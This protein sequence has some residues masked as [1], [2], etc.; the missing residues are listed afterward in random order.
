[1]K[2]TNEHKD[3][4]GLEPSLE[5]EAK[6]ASGDV[7]NEIDKYSKLTHAAFYSGGNIEEKITISSPK[8]QKKLLHRPEEEVVHCLLKVYNYTH[9]SNYEIINDGQPPQHDST[10]VKIID[11]TTGRSEEIQVTVSDSGAMQG[12]GRNKGRLERKGESNELVRAALDKAING[13][14]FYAIDVRQNLILALDGWRTV[15]PNNLDYYREKQQ[16]FMADSG[17]KEI[18]FVGYTDKTI[19][20]LSP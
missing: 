4:I 15:K 3:K 1:M 8:E 18:W 20:R 14:L 16:Q 13:K 6:K 7:Y 19:L 9:N 5:I 17:F 12:L 2:H 10:D 11:K